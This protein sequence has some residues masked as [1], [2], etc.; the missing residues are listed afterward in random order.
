MTIKHALRDGRLLRSKPEFEDC[1]ALARKHGLPLAEVYALVA[2]R[3]PGEDGN[4]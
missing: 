4:A 1:R 2:G 3:R